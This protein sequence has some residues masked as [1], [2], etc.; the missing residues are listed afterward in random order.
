ME[1]N[2]DVI[3]AYLSS[4][5]G[6]EEYTQITSSHGTVYGDFSF[7]MILDRGGFNAIPHTIAYR[8]TTMTVI[9]EG[10][11]PLC[12]N[13]KQLGHFSRSCPQ[14]ATT[15]VTK[16]TTT[17]TNDTTESNTTTEAKDNTLQETEVQ[18]DKNEGWT[19]VKGGKKKK[20]TKTKNTEIKIHEEMET[21][22]NLK[23]RRDSGDAEKEG[24]KKQLKTNSPKP[25]KQKPQPLQPQ[26]P[27]PQRPAEKP[28]RPEQNSQQPE[29]TTHPPTQRPAQIIP[30]PQQPKS[31]PIKHPKIPLH[32]TLPSL[33]SISTPKQF[34]RSH[35][36][37]RSPSPSPST[38][39]KKRTK[40]ASNQ[41][42]QAVNGFYFCSDLLEAPNL[43][44]HLK[45]AL[46]PLSS[47]K[48]INE[49]DI[50]NPY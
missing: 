37:T 44:H 4:Y 49:K 22:T 43:D 41:L 3:A 17:A 50:T 47:M 23:R 26:Q 35:S 2:G 24:E 20:E 36:E 25:E 28:K 16:K 30:L 7:T 15:I 8:T 9:V 38:A 32:P 11:K 45:K 12:W 29:K 21:T 33:S 14:K 31:T 39:Q 19:L 5:G 10:R 1:L 46:K 42:R 6:V 13:C 34:T 48:K 18:P 27:A 40:S